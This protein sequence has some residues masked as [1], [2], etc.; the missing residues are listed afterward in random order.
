MQPGILKGWQKQSLVNLTGKNLHSLSKTFSNSIWQKILNFKWRQNDQNMTRFFVFFI[1]LKKV[2]ELIFVF[3]IFLFVIE[4]YLIPKIA[5]CFW[6]QTIEKM[7]FLKLQS[8][9]F[10]NNLTNSS[11]DIDKEHLGPP[12]SSFD[13]Y[14][15]LFITRARRQ[16]VVRLTFTTLINALAT[17]LLHFMLWKRC[18]WSSFMIWCLQVK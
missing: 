18:K 4:A 6:S 1:S 8:V 5:S 3:S 17:K 16:L 14:R 9:I 7:V 2:T 15:P 10:A 13:T 12:W 11:N